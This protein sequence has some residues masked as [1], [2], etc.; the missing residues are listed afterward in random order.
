MANNKSV[1]LVKVITEYYMLKTVIKNEDVQNIL[2]GS[3]PSAGATAY[4]DEETLKQMSNYVNALGEMKIS[5]KKIRGKA[6]TFDE[7]LERLIQGF[8]VK[9]ES[10]DAKKRIIYSEN[11]FEKEFA[12]LVTG[13]LAMEG[14]EDKI[15]QSLSLN[16]QINDK[17]AELPI[18]LGKEKQSSY[19]KLLAQ[20]TDIYSN[21]SGLQN[22]IAVLKESGQAKDAKIEELQKALDAEIARAND[23]KNL[24][25]N[26][27]VTLD[28]LKVEDFKAV[29]VL[30]GQTINNLNEKISQDVAVQGRATRKH[31]TNEADRVID[32]TEQNM[33]KKE[34][35]RTQILNHPNMYPKYISVTK[36]KHIDLN[37]KNGSREVYDEIQRAAK[38]VNIPEDH[39]AVVAV[40][41]DLAEKNMAN[42]AQSGDKHTGVKV[43]AGVLGI[44]LLAGGAFAGG[45]MMRNNQTT[46]T[47]YKTAEEDAQY[48]AYAKRENEQR[49]NYVEKLNKA[50][51]DGTLLNFDDL[52]GLPQFENATA[53]N[54]EESSE[55][56]D[57]NYLNALR[58]TYAQDDNLD[59]Y[60]WSSTNEI[61][62]LTNAAVQTV[63]ANYYENNY[64]KILSL[65]SSIDSQI[66]DITQQLQTTGQVDILEP[67]TESI[68]K[69]IDAIQDV[70]DAAQEKYD[71]DTSELQ[72]KIDE[73]QQKLDEANEK[74]DALQNENSELKAEN[75]RLQSQVNDLSSKLSELLEEINNLKHEN[76]VLST[77][78]ASLQTQVYRYEVQI[79]TLQERVATLEESEQ[80]EL[81]AQIDALQA[82]LDEANATIAELQSTNETLTNQITELNSSIDQ[83]NSDV[84]A[85]EDAVNSLTAENSS[86]Q[87]QVSSLQESLTNAI[88][89][90]N[91]L[92]AKYN[93]LKESGGNS[94][95]VEALRAE[96]AAAYSKIS[97]YENK[98][99]ALYNGLTKSN[100]SSEEA[101]NALE[102]LL[103]VFGINYTDQGADYYNSSNEYEPGE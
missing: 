39:P 50:I 88:S 65:V 36:G 11:P 12:N 5:S 76:S 2:N 63:R 15:R 17:I 57:L 92:L 41:N 51:E 18:L 98:I 84:A 73:L 64:A 99:V 75:A 16:M 25:Q 89:N 62:A 77:E 22:E 49:D 96:L 34:D 40:Y 55:V 91:D 24:V 7:F 37:L 23:Y 29:M 56:I 66:L 35:I 21:I 72:Q 87:E 47:Q 85:L 68:Q 3:V 69:L 74:I 79:V 95:E 33:Y 80:G 53:K 60:K 9:E 31:V 28:T 32:T 4:R 61:D 19:V 101:M 90:Y 71:S 100:A 86:L 102:E 52:E 26:Q 45:Y 54:A 8:V 1:N 103:R 93:E 13:I 44:A 46:V 59:G 94:E 43:V 20:Y 97:T 38:S 83:L 14:A 78:K 27:L 10:K 82:L 6:E 30:L 42:E 67:Q 48:Q 58:D 70:L 81:L